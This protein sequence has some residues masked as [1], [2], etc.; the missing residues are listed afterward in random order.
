MSHAVL[1]VTSV[2]CT[3]APN[4][5]TLAVELIRQPVTLVPTA[6]L[7]NDLAFAFFSIVQV[8]ALVA[9][10]IYI[11]KNS[12]AEFLRSALDLTRCKQQ[13]YVP[14]PDGNSLRTFDLQ[15]RS[16]VRYLRIGWPPKFL[17]T[18]NRLAILLCL[19]HISKKG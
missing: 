8:V 18:M 12:F 7:I 17:R 9:R 2:F 19:D 15:R 11:D 16:K 1:P 4:H 14:C 6:I 3:I 5:G 10:A 13:L